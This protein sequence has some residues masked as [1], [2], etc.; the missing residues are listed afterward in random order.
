VEEM[1]PKEAV[2]RQGAIN[3]NR[4]DLTPYEKAKGYKLAWETGYFTS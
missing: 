2:R 1:S 3:E 4:A